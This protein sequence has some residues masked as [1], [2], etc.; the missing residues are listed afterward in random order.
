MGGGGGGKSAFVP[1]GAHYIR[2]TTSGQ[3]EKEMRRFF[4]T[5][6]HVDGNQTKYPWTLC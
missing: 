5:R 4:D 2:P 3:N 1:T 6:T